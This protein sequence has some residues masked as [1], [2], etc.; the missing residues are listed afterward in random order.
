MKTVAILLSFLTLTM[1]GYGEQT[2]QIVVQRNNIGQQSPSGG[3]DGP[4][5]V[6]RTIEPGRQLNSDITYG[7]VLP[8]L[9]RRKTHFLDPSPATPAAPLLNVSINPITGRA[10]GVIVF[11][12][13]F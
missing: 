13:R 7:G 1:V 10:E 3:K 6:P 2:N 12:I 9:K 8:E 4:M 11:S 5:L